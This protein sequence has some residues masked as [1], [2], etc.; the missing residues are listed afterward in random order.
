MKVSNFSLKMVLLFVA[1]SSLRILKADDSGNETVRSTSLGATLHF[2]EGSGG[3]MTASIGPDG[4]FLVDTDFSEMA[5]KILKK[6]YELKGGTPRFIVNTHFHYDHTGGN[7]F[8]GKTGTIIAAKEVRSRLNTEQF[9]WKKTHP[10]FPA[11]ALPTLTFEREISLY[12][13]GEQIRIR[14]IAHSHTDGD[15]VVFFEKSKIVSLGDLYFS[16]MYPIF[17]PEHL[18]DLKSLLKNLKQIASWI[19]ADAQIVPGHG[20]LSGKS[21]FL[22]Y[23]RMIEVSIKIVKEGVHAGKSLSQIIDKGLPKEWESFSHGY[24]STERWLT[25]IYRSL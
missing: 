16:G 2:L 19:P 21:E 17:H 25:A 24:S 1:F 9:L 12:F 11:V 8:F 5:E 20:P 4:T 7:S 13:N 23:I 18:G 15:T 14:H 6:L 22:R 3:N 10:A